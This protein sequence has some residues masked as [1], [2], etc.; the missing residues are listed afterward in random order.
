M[1]GRFIKLRE[2]EPGIYV[3]STSTLPTLVTAEWEKAK[4]I[5]RNYHEVGRLGG[6]VLFKTKLLH[7]LTDQELSEMIGRG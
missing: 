5:V 1:T 2:I 3:I 6:R 7:D 4:L